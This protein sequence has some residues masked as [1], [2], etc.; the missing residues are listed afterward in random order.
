[1]NKS[2]TIFM[3]EEWHHWH[4]NKPCPNCGSHDIE[5]NVTLVL[6]SNPPQNQLRCKAC[7][8][9]FCSGI[10]A[11]CGSVGTIF[12]GEPRVQQGWQ[13]PK[14]GNVLAPHIDFC[15]FCQ[16]IDT[17]VISASSTENK[18]CLDNTAGKIYDYLSDGLV[19]VKVKQ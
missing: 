6:T 11:E 14:C 9:I 12:I 19:G 16:Q 2:T 1:M 15:P 4:G 5:Y 10:E 7:G 17:T 13:C 8:H 3:G 18:V